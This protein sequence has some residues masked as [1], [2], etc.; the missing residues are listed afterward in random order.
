MNKDT[1]IKTLEEENLKLVQDIQ[2][3]KDKE[4]DLI[5]CQ[6]GLYKDYQDLELRHEL[7]LR[8]LD[9]SE[10]QLK[11]V[12]DNLTERAWM[13]PAPQPIIINN[14]K[15]RKNSKK[16]PANI[17]KKVDKTEK[18]LIEKQMDEALKSIADKWC[19]EDEEPKAHYND[20][21]TPF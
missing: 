16:L 12:M 10:K 20:E 19:D 3:Y 17:L 2:K 18:I 1:Y 11:V 6:D 5:N 13:Q 7:A 9:H 4:K 21:R 15:K 14:P 8:T